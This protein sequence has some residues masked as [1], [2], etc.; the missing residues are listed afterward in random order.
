MHTTGSTRLGASGAV[1]DK[2]NGES[3]PTEVEYATIRPWP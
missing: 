3:A 2:Q 1:T